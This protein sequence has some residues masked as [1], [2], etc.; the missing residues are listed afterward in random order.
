MLQG[1]VLFTVAMQG[2]ALGIVRSMVTNTAPIAWKIVFSIQ[3]PVAVLLFSALWVPEYV[4]TS[5]ADFCWL[6]SS[7]QIFIQF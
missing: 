6:S 7:Y 3:W 2:T 4:K 1:I 5:I